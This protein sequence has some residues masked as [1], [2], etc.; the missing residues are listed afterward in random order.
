ML[1]TPTHRTDD[2][3]KQLRGYLTGALHAD[4]ELEP[5]PGD[6]KLPVFLTRRYTF[7]RA[8]IAARPCLFMATP[9]AEPTPA[10]IGKHMAQVAPM[11]GDILIYAAP[12]MSA[13]MRARLVAL[14]IAFAVPGNQLYIPQLAMDLREH[15]RAPDKARGERLTP[16]AQLVLFHHLLGRHETTT[17]TGLARILGYTPMSLG[18]AID[19][20]AQRNLATVEWQGREKT[21]VYPPHHRTLLENSRS[22]LRSP[23]RGYHAVRFQAQV[24]TLLRAGETA[25]ADLTNLGPPATPVYAITGAGWQEFFKTHAIC[26]LHDIEGADAMIET[27]RYD[28]SRLEEGGHVDPLSLYAQFWDHPDERVAQAAADVLETLHW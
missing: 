15:F 16:A 23:K 18:R 24:P 11:N 1:Q 12:R 4:I 9:S 27:W 5:W 22:L 28:P 21:I 10:E 17:A 25:L 7:Y 3:A 20:L 26:D 19:E 8:T 6:T 2:F 13:T 14:G